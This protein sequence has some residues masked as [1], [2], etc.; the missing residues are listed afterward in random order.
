MRKEFPALGE[1]Y[2]EQTLRC[3]MPVR[4][5]VKPG[6]ARSYAFLA[7]NFGSI[8]TRFTANGKTHVLPDGVAHYLEHKMFDLPNGSAMDEFAKWG[9]SNNAFTNYTMTAY[10]VECTERF[11]ENLRV[12]L[13]MVT[14]PYFTPE[15]VEKERGIIAQEIRM[16]EDSADSAVFE[17]LFKT[18]YRAHPA[19]VPIAGTVESIGQIT[20]QT[21]RDA[22]EAFYHPANMMLCVMGDVEPEKVFSEAENAIPEQGPFA[23]PV[24]DYGPPEP[25]TGHEARFE[26]K[27]EVSMP[28]FALGFKCPPDGI[29]QEALGDLAA[30]MLVGES[31][32]LYRKLYE[33]NKIDSDF[34][35]GLERMKGLSVFEAVG[36]SE[37][38]DEVAAEIVKEAQRLCREGLDRAQFDRLKKSALGRRTRDLDSFESACYHLC[39]SYFE[40]AEYFEYPA[41]YESLSAEDAEQF[42]RENVL[43]ERASI[44]VV[45]PKK[46]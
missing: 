10:Y 31:S 32:A 3:G 5:I 13:S 22:Y 45:F 29:R 43:Q 39:A 36:D 23:V 11:F 12:L 35:A 25:L 44:S 34:S 24:R 20:D 37:C 38:P 6:F 41:V 1:Q 9:G 27:M 19:R 30:E 40:G 4:V 42:L 17:N 15:S 46:E 33:E 26:T 28:T 21:L 7:V 14:T 16:Y 8:D 18:M 2:E